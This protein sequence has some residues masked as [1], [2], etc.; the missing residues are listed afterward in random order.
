MPWGSPSSPGGPKN[1]PKNHFKIFEMPKQPV[2]PLCPCAGLKK[3][4]PQ[5]IEKYSRFLN[6]Q[7]ILYV[8]VQA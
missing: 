4:S 1:Y 3:K 5:N 8:P 6:A 7:E 2:N